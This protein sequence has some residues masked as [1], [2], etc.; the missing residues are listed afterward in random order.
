[1]G[2]GKRRIR[3]FRRQVGWQKSINKAVKAFKKCAK[4]FCR[5]QRE[6]LEKDPSKGELPPTIL[7]IIRDWARK[8]SSKLCVCMQSQEREAEKESFEEDH[9]IGKY[10]STIQ[11]APQAPD[12]TISRSVCSQP[13][14]LVQD[15]CCSRHCIRN[16]IKEQ[17]TSLWYQLSPSFSDEDLS[18]EP[19]PPH[20]F[21]KILRERNS[22]DYMERMDIEYAK[23]RSLAK[24]RPSLFSDWNRPNPFFRLPGNTPPPFPSD[25]NFNKES[26]DCAESKQ[27]TPTVS[28]ELEYEVA[29]DV[30]DGIPEVKTADTEKEKT[31]DIQI[32]MAVAERVNWMLEQ[33]ENNVEENSSNDSNI[34]DH[35]KL[36]ETDVLSTS[37]CNSLQEEAAVSILK[38]NEE[39]DDRELDSLSVS[40]DMSSEDNE[41]INIRDLDSRASYVVDGELADVTSLISTD[42]T[43]E[44]WVDEILFGELEVVGREMIS[45]ATYIIEQDAS[46]LEPIMDEKSETPIDDMINEILENT[47]SLME[48][49]KFKDEKNKSKTKS[50]SKED[51][52]DVDKFI[53]DFLFEPTL[54]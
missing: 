39:C 26:E 27:L 14:G 23:I 32:A 9:P 48:E 5:R 15:A 33:V 25:W 35:V 53:Q 44:Q 7:N 50:S 43:C 19:T 38:V 37:S 40:V 52:E 45:R 3:V 10:T 18:R 28:P 1:M 20:P 42:E 49:E 24:Q 54:V 16:N 6:E 13:V 17:A 29:N 46:Y 21:E 31:T 22:L 4:L 36:N 11:L 8:Q 47:K 41:E 51:P 12:V 34:K 2:Q 30:T